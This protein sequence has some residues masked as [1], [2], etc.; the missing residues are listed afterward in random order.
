M[1]RIPFFVCIHWMCAHFCSV[2][3][4]FILPLGVAF[5]PWIYQRSHISIRSPPL[6][7]VHFFSSSSI[8]IEMP[9]NY[10]WINCQRTLLYGSKRVEDIQNAECNEHTCT[11]FLIEIAS[12]SGNEGNGMG[13]DT[14]SDSSL[15]SSKLSNAMIYQYFMCIGC[16]RLELNVH[17]Q[18]AMIDRK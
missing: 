12:F 10:L 13:R 4:H 6:K 7:L 18:R 9:F 1:R 16:D 5:L 8:I 11:T 15:C 3:T 14:I 2:L 17:I